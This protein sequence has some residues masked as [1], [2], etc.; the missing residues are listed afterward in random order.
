MDDQGALSRYFQGQRPSLNF[1]DR[2][3]LFEPRLRTPMANSALHAN[4]RLSPFGVYPEPGFDTRE[5]AWAQAF[6][7]FGDPVR[8][9]EATARIALR[10]KLE[11]I[12]SG[13]MS[14]DLN[15]QKR[16][17]DPPVSHPAPPPRPGALR[18]LSG[19]I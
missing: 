3:R 17:M 8:S 7:P 19:E 11:R 4:A 18:A 12:L 9:Q 10:E 15:L 16:K 1:E 13:P 2:R 5:A 6:D 14:K